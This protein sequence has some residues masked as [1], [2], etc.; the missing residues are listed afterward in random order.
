M[1]KVVH[2]RKS[3]L[4]H[5]HLPLVAGFAAIVFSCAA[6]AD[7]YEDAVIETD[8]AS[9]RAIVLP[10]RFVYAFT[11]TSGS[12]TVTLKDAECVN[13]TLVVAGGGAGGYGVSGGGGGGGVLASDTVRELAANSTITLSVG[14]GGGAAFSNDGPSTNGANSVLTISATTQTAIGGGKGGS[15]KQDTAYAAGGNGGSGGGSTFNNSYSAGTGTSGQGYEGAKWKSTKPGPGAG[16][17]ASV[18]ATDHETETGSTGGEGVSNSITGIACVYGSGGGNGGGT[19]NNATYVAGKG[20]TNAGDGGTFIGKNNAGNVVGGDGV[21]GTGGGGGGAS[22]SGGSG[23]VALSFT[24]T[25]EGILTIASNMDVPSAALPSVGLGSFLTKTNVMASAADTT[26]DSLRYVCKGYAVETYDE[27]L[28]SWSSPVTNAVPV[29]SFSDVAGKCVRV[30][31]LWEKT[32]DADTIYEDRAIMSTIP[33]A[34]TKVANG[35]FAYVFTETGYRGTVLLK[36]DAVVSE[37]LVVAGGGGGG[38][39][40][41]GGGGGGGVIYASG[42]N[43]ALN[44]ADAFTFVVG[45]G[46]QGA[47]GN[48]TGPAMNGYDSALSFAVTNFV[49]IGGGK[50]G[51]WK[52]EYATGGNGG[53]GGGSTFSNQQAAGT[54][55]AGQGND[56]GKA[57]QT[58]PGGGGGAMAPG[59]QKS[60]DNVSGI[61][62]AGLTCSITGIAQVYGSGGGAGGGKN[63]QITTE[64]SPGKGGANAGD[65]GGNSG[66][67][68]FGGGGGGG[69][70][71]GAGGNGGSGV[72]VIRILPNLP[73]LGF[74]LIFK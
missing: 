70:V 40:I 26:V 48:T 12:V 47:V 18:A 3:A 51:S 55:T 33:F 61:G 24:P 58:G 54:G 43:L 59:G 21:D 45:A 35:D 66:V 64:I 57:K 37:S 63:T 46:G 65:G 71:N 34:K 38:Y 6:L 72:V 67:D 10:T 42:L 56:G 9:V 17:G 15:W 1:N 32:L 23:I 22:G 27:I 16:G 14:V 49:A 31:W 8:D 60:D 68:G 25:T 36:T 7:G 73:K 30:T 13:R 44:A 20:G 5:K 19:A 28:D 41:G 11:N 39:S 2:N 29:Y 62:G 4:H 69:N 52:Q 74:S 50:G 53:S